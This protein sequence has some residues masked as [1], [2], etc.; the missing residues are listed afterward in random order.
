MIGGGSAGLSLGLVTTGGAPTVKSGENIAETL[1]AES[2]VSAHVRAIPPHAPLHP[3]QAAQGTDGSAVNVIWSPAVS[4][5]LHVV[6]EHPRVRTE[7]N[8]V[9]PA[10]T[11]SVR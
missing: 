2:M 8:T 1:L 4:I 10:D 6:E 3:A 11:V 7:L 9:P 5:Q